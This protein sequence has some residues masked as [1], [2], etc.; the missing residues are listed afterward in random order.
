MIGAVGRE[1]RDWLALAGCPLDRPLIIHLLREVPS[2]RAILELGDRELT[3]RFGLGTRQVAALRRVPRT[4]ELDRQE[5]ELDRCG[6]DVLPVTHAAFPRN[7]FQMRIPPP[8]LFAKGTL[9]EEDLLAVGIVGPRKATPYGIQVA[10]R[11]AADFAPNLTVVSGAALG[12]DSTAHE[13]ALDNGGRTL[14][15]LGCGIDVNYPSGNEAL[16]HRIATEGGALL[17]VYPPGTP[18]L[19]GH[20]PARN[21]ILAGMSLAV[22]VIEATR[23]SGA[24]V[25]ARAAGEE[26]RPVYAVPGDITRKN[27]EGSNLLLRDGAIACTSASDVLADL[28]PVLSGELRTLAER[29]RRPLAPSP[30]SSEPAPG[31]SPGER[32]VLE[33]IQHH[34]ISH[35]ELID[36]LVPSSLSLGELSTALLMLEMGGRILQAPGRRYM[37]RL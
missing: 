23:T 12:V 16:R 9:I 36:K 7:L 4:E 17:S 3:E 11:L 19:R 21:F 22:I 32:T 30:D 2:P 33:M 14:A 5:R 35:D 26:G 25:T 1:R 6:I 27:S 37:V 15:V 31:L 13:A 10:R 29:R 8:V 28:E 24:L 18:P 34:E 20:F